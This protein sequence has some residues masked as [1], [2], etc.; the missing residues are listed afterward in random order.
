[1]RSVAIFYYS[2]TGNTEAAARAVADS[3]P[4][5][6]QAHLIR[7]VPTEPRWQLAVPFVPMW[8]TFFGTAP[9]TALGEPVAITTEPA[10]W[11]AVDGVVIG[12]STWW[13]RPCLPI[14]SLVRSDRFRSYVRGLP[15]GLFAACRGFYR[16]NLRALAHA[17]RGAGARVVAR[18]RFTFTGSVLRTFLAFFAVLRFG[19]PRQRW[20]GL[21]LPPYGF[22]PETLGR[23]RGFAARFVAGAT[24]R[25][26]V[27]EGLLRAVRL[28]L[29]GLAVFD[30]ALA[31]AFTV[32]SHR[33]VQAIAPPG[34]AEPVFFQRSVGVF[35]LQYV[36]IQLLAFADPRRWATAITMTIA[37]RATFAVLYVAEVVLWGRPFTALHGLFLA[38][39]ALDTATASFLWVAAH[40]LGISLLGGDAVV[41]P[42]APSGWPLRVL[43]GVLAVVQLVIGGGWLVAPVALCRLFDITY[44]VDPFWARATG[45]L[46]VHIAFIHYLGARDPHRYRSAV[47]TSGVF[48]AVWPVLYWVSI[49]RGEGNALFRTAILVSSFC[50]IAICVAIFWFV[51]RMSAQPPARVGI[52]AGT[53]G[54]AR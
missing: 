22:S 47:L 16:E 40:R 15:V 54:G 5:G 14:Q 11:P 36:F 46:L 17:V 28:G 13:N 48:S 32:F 30:L 50:D 27:H 2:L 44:V 45:V 38:A 23:A 25:E 19:M 34:Y 51:H 12:S 1:M 20:L 33:A 39:A 24:S 35:L 10:V 21:R 3:L 8:R 41:A 31:I 53:G 43:L 6:C 9:P 42:A 4:A 18:E 37:V 26:P 49:A 29:I 52:L 7:V